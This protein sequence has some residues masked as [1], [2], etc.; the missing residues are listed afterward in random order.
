MINLPEVSTVYDVMLTGMQ[1]FVLQ[2]PPLDEAHFFITLS[3][4]SAIV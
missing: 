3:H 4:F 1:A 2:S